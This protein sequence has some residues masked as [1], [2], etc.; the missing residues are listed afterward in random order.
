MRA[1]GKEREAAN[2]RV[3]YDFTFSQPKSVSIA[4]LVGHDAWIRENNFAP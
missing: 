1:D 2:R 3:F 4:A